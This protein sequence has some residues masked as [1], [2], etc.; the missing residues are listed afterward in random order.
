MDEVLEL[1]RRLALE[2]GSGGR[3]SAAIR[4]RVMA[5]CESEEGCGLREQAER[6][7]IPAGTLWRWLARERR[8]KAESS[9]RRVVVLGE[10]A[11]RVS[12]G[13]VLTT[14]G[15]VRIEGLT[16]SEALEVSRE[17]G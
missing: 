7:G 12:S 2:R 1:R 14:P 9:F 3:Y 10:S 8:P 5:Y 17:W 6:L 15:G 11:A 4:S 16:L 13:L